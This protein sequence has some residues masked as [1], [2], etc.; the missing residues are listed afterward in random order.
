M[1]NQ[2]KRFAKFCLMNAFILKRLTQ[3]SLKTENR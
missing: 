1:K 3:L 2:I